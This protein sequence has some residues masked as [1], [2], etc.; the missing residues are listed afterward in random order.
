MGWREFFLRFCWG[1]TSAGHRDVPMYLRAGG[2]GAYFRWSQRREGCRTAG[3]Q[4][5]IDAYFRGREWF[6][7]RH[8]SWGKLGL[9]TNLGGHE[10]FFRTVFEPF[11]DV[12]HVAWCRVA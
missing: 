11:V 3:S 5:G 2:I 1:G 4:F 8:T 7:G 10:R 6:A 12:D 9:D